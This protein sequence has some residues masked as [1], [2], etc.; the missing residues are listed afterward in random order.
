M[1]RSLRQSQAPWAH[2][3]WELWCAGFRH[4][5]GLHAR[6]ILDGATCRLRELGDVRNVL[7]VLTD[8]AACS[9]VIGGR[10]NEED[11]VLVVK[12]R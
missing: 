7:S 3:L 5:A 8:C 10:V 4:S 12:G 1:L 11:E 9:C 6:V 2:N